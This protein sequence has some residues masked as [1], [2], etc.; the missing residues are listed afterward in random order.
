MTRA[1][2]TIRRLLATC[3]PLLLAGVLL[4]AGCDFL[5]KE[6]KGA[7]TSANF[8]ESERQAIQATNATYSTLREWQVHVFSWLGM[9]DIASDDATKGSTPSDAG[10]L[11]ELD[12]LTF[13]PG[14]LAFRD[15]WNGY[16]KGI[17]RANVAI[18]NIPNVDM[19]PDLRTRL[20]AENRF[21]R[22]YFYFFLVRA[23]GG[24]P[25][26]TEPLAPGEFEQPRAPRDSV[27]ALIEQ[28]LE[29]AAA[30]LPP[31]YAADV[32]RATQGAAHGLL[33][34]VHLFQGEY[35]AALEHAEAVIASGDYDLHGDYFTIFRPEGEFSEESVFEIANAAF[36][37]GGGSSQ[38]AQVEGGRGTQNLGWGF[39]QPCAA[40]EAAYE[41]GDPRLQ[42]TILYP[43]ETLPDG[44]G[45]VVHINPNIPNQ[46]Y[47]EKVQAPLDTPGGSGN[48]TVNI[49]R[50]RYADVLL[51]AAEAAAR[52]GDEETS[53]TYLNWVRE[54]ARGGRTVTL[55]LQPENMAPELAAALEVDDSAPHVFV[56]YAA[57]PAAAAGVQSF[58][59]EHREGGEPLPVTVENAD[60][61]EAVNGAPVSSVAEYVDALSS[62]APGQTVSLDVLRLAQT[63]DGNGGV[64]TSS[65][66]L[67]IDV[68]A[69]ALLPDVTAGGQDLLEAIWHERR[70]ELAME[71]HRW[72]DIIRQGRAPEIMAGIGVDFRDR[73]TLYP[74]PQSEIDVTGGLLEQN[75]GYSN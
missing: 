45:A 46:R 49:R 26:I 9:T 65:Q 40:L 14:N 30:N 36:E 44:S 61:I 56:R 15:T 71:Q 17:Y 75:P 21:L 7:L 64:T 52:T 63:P 72:F 33:A 68:T 42:A 41:P 43:W 2:I 73:H 20:V 70:V 51:I 67:T 29:F 27:Y 4:L 18:Q 48:S 47:N 5:D 39:N 12:N 1:T 19:D 74:I 69:E 25:L 62:V 58:S 24:V 10:F 37:E 66:A 32:G 28:D 59:S 6:P 13:D 22:A 3:L 16:Y 55:G 53:R 31:S 60:V 57:G 8:F 23:F 34:K 50:L 54:R 11:R 38:Y 35:E